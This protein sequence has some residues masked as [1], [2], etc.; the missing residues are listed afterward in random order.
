[1]WGCGFVWRW[2][3]GLRI[4]GALLPALIV[5]WIVW[6]THTCTALAFLLCSPLCVTHTFSHA[7]AEDAAAVKAL[8]EKHQEELAKVRNEME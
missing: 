6:S 4:C 3:V 1:V 2:G 5:P 7:Q 8:V